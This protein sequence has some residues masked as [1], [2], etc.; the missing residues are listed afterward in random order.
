MPLFRVRTLAQLASASLA[1]PRLLLT[2]MSLFASAALLVAAIGLYGL[3]AQAVAA[4]VREIGVRRAVGATTLDVA[5]L[6]AR[7]TARTVG[8]GAAIGVAVSWTISG[9]LERFVYGAGGP[10]VAAYATAVAVLTGVA[11]LAAFAPCRRAVAVDPAAALR[12]E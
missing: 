7:Q 9:A 3:L 8:A 6:I 11:L 10:D 4:R 12:G 5:G 2:L 1:Q